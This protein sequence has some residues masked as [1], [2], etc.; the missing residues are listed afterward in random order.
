MRGRGEEGPRMFSSSSLVMMEVAPQTDD[1]TLE[2][3][4]TL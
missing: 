1:D 3:R 4:Q 2:V